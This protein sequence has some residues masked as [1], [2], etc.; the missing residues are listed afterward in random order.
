MIRFSAT[1]SAL[2]LGASSLALA[3]P[4]C[5]T[6]TLFSTSDTQIEEGK[7]TNQVAGLTQVRLSNGGTASF[8]DAADYKVNA[9][10]TVDL[11][12]GAVT[13]TSGSNGEETLV[14]M[15]EGVEGRIVGASS[16][17]SFAVGPDGEVRGHSLSGSVRI[18]RSGA[19]RR[20][21][22][23]AMFAVNTAGTPRQVV[24]NGAQTVPSAAADEVPVVTALGGEA[25]PVAAAQNGIPV[26][27]GDALA[28]AGASGDILGAARRVEAAVG[29]PA[30]ETFPS[31]DLSLLVAAAAG[32]ETAFGGEPFDAAQADIIRAYIGFLAAGGSGAD[33]LTAYSGFLVQ[34]F[35]LLRTGG[36]PGDFGLVG[37]DDIDAFTLFFARTQGF[38]TLSSQDRALAEA[39]LAF[40]SNGGVADDFV[41]TFTDLTEAYFAFLR[42]GGVPQD[43]ADASLATAESYIAFLDASGLAENLSATDRSLLEA[44]IANGG[45][46]FVAQ[47]R[48]DLDAYLAFLESGQRPSDYDGADIAVLLG[49]VQTLQASGLL[50]TVLEDDAAFFADYAAFVQGGGEIDA[51]DQLN[52]N[53]FTAYAQ[54]LDAYFAFLDA[55]GTPS[56]Y[57]DFEV[58][59]LNAYLVELAAAGALER[60][61]GSRSAF[62]AD[63]L[64]FL[65]GGG[66]LDTFAQL[67]ANVFASYAED[68]AAYFAYLEQGGVPSLYTELDQTT[69]RSYLAALARVGA[70]NGFLAD[71]AA[72][73][74]DYFAFIEGG[75]NPDNFAGLPVPP[76][77]PAFA[78]ALNAYAAF[79]Q[80]GGLPTNYNAVD[81]A[82]LQN[83]L[84]A[85]IASGQLADRLGN[86]A[87]LL[88]GYFAFLAAGGTLDGFS[89]L[90][91]YASY[92]DELNAYYLF[93]ENGGLP[94]D[95]AEL[96]Q[97]TIETYLAALNGAG[98]FAA[99]GSLDTFF[100]DYFAFISAGGDPAR[101]AGIPVYAE[102]VTALNAYFAFITDGGLPARYSVLDIA[103]VRSY[104]S[105]LSGA[106]GLTAFAGLDT[107]FADYFAFIAAGGDPSAFAGLPVFADYTEA[108]NAYF[109]FIAAGGLPGDYAE[110]D[111]ATIRAYV[112]ALEG[113]GGQAVF[114]LDTAFANYYA[115]IAAGGE[116][117][118]FAG[119]PVF[120]EYVTALNAYFAFLADGGVPSEYSILTQAQISAYLAA[121]S[122]T[123]GGFANFA[124]LN[125]FFV[126]YFAFIEEGGNPDQFA[127]LPDAG[128]PNVPGTPS[129]SSGEVVLA[130]SSP[131]SDLFGV[132]SG[133]TLDE[134]GAIT[135]VQINDSQAFNFGGSNESLVESGRIGD[136]VAWSRYQRSGARNGFTNQTNHL[137][138]GAPAVDLPQSGSIEYALLGG[139]APTD[140][141]GAEGS[142][143]FFE[144]R[145]AV[146]FRQTALP[147]I[148]LDLNI[149]TGERGWNVRTARGADQPDF[150]GLLLN[151]DGTFSDSGNQLATTGIKGDACEGSC[152]TFLFGGLF[153]EGASHAGFSYELLDNSN[154]V[155]SQVSGVAV[156][157]RQGMAVAGLGDVAV[158]N[159]TGD[160]GGDMG[161]GIGG[162]PGGGGGS[163]I[164]FL[165][166]DGNAAPGT[167]GDQVTYTGAAGPGVGLAAP[168]DVT[169]GVLLQADLNLEQ[170]T[171]VPSEQ[172]E[173]QTGG[174]EGVLGW[175]RINNVGG[176]ATNGNRQTFALQ[177]FENSYVHAVWGTPAF[178]LPTT[179]IINYDLVGW[180]TPTANLS[181]DTT[182]AT[183]DGSLAL[184][185]GA[186]AVGL[187]ATV[188][189]PEQSYSFATSGGVAAP[190]LSINANPSSGRGL[191]F[192]ANLDTLDGSGRDVTRRT[193]VQGFL[194]GENASHVGLTYGIRAASNN[195]IQGSAAFRAAVS[196]GGDM[197]GGDGGVSSAPDGEVPLSASQGSYAYEGHFGNGAS[198][199]DTF[200]VTDGVF[201]EARLSGTFN[202]I[203]YTPNAATQTIVDGDQGVIAWQRENNI[204]AFADSAFG[205]SRAPA[206]A[207][208]FY[209]TVWGA[210]VVNLPTMGLV[211]YELIGATEATSTDGSGIR[212][213]FTGALA[214]DFVGY[215][216]GVE[217]S[218]AF[219]DVTYAFAS[220]GGVDAPSIALFTSGRDDIFFDEIVSATKD[221]SE[222]A[223]GAYLQGFLAGDGASHAGLTYAIRDS[224]SVTIEGAAAFRVAGSGAGTAAGS[225]A[226]TSAA[227][228]LPVAS[229]GAV[230]GGAVPPPVPPVPATASLGGWDR[231]VAPRPSTNVPAVPVPA[232][233]NGRVETTGTPEQ[234]LGDWITFG[235]R[236][237]R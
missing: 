165:A 178:D 202:G 173:T 34:Y 60:F 176:T 100:V 228:M 168:I 149:Y 141:F 169:D 12:Q 115:F 156:Y 197:G 48:A 112:A 4:A 99:Y 127:G 97:T 89:G 81:L 126:D 227:A 75:G 223:L 130:Q 90:P 231:W 232:T 174:S 188:T 215:D 52:A 42:S 191:F 74:T 2:M 62:F 157:G 53:I 65:Q 216:V 6:Q 153:G 32:L 162:E 121:L 10:G 29:N 98:G 106:G 135:S 192:S 213:T 49:Y 7:R 134:N 187:E 27:L 36:S 23:G 164:A 137:L 11:Y 54:A 159:V 22:N 144:G 123:T 56:A 131:Y 67:N 150:A 71:L 196:A 111:Q 224:N 145:M 25:G 198:T 28:A 50:D 195:T 17:A 207:D 18:G 84:E 31:G 233:A 72:F 204:E 83:Y 185:F 119:L 139:T 93:L 3:A 113:A 219:G 148:G 203:R 158:K 104:I 70:T 37:I 85:I 16:A 229:A 208:R 95:Y 175:S 230:P 217:G 92:V 125:A 41:G 206:G 166:G 154:A 138:V 15:P 128:G 61:L 109:A 193:F 183:F 225:I 94:G 210:P 117:S 182:G 143:G 86:N 73:Y 116:P 124:G 102:Y 38:A 189:L 218:V 45:F 51:F 132:V 9:D 76:D 69:I 226:P 105:A 199:A 235:G 180:T 236:Q 57:A 194:A 151:E 58:D 152:S 80:G 1:A 44:Y 129:I 35:D 209:H 118:G 184:D 55:G 211:S 43:F 234:P 221:G 147:E 68:L 13:V 160:T 142:A 212:G 186:L 110:L 30:I 24:S 181:T 172:S 167:A 114:D 88:T 64:A 5:A 200:V 177:P 214:V 78:D 120:A 40:L 237:T 108:L 161:G 19:L 205:G 136:T 59:V 155:S 122:G 220:D 46:G 163:D 20:F 33:F 79:L 14:R 77:F 140:A 133:A 201:R 91:L 146:A 96:D 66:T 170:I 82:L 101:F 39:Y 103:T 21:E 63:Y 190:S 87:D 107:G 171:L 47:Y 8:L 222:L 179:G 26:L